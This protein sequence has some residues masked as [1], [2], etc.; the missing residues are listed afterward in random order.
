[1]VWGISTHGDGTAKT[2]AN[3]MEAVIAGAGAT[4]CLAGELHF[5]QVCAAETTT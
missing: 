3:Q 4:F 1:L 2:E 5:V